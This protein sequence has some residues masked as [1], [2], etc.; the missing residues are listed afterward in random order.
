MKPE[1]LLYGLARGVTER[2]Q[3]SLLK[4][5]MTSRADA[6]PIIER[7]KADGFHSFRIATY[8]GEKPDFVAAINRGNS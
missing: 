2:W 6:A 7:A 8:S 4:T 1:Y 5:G 3:E